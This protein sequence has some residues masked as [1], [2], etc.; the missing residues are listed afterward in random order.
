MKEIFTKFG[1]TQA[2]FTKAFW[3][4][5][6]N[7]IFAAA[8]IIAI[9]IFYKLTARIIEA[10]LRRTAMQPS[11]IRIAVHSI[12]KSTIAAVAVIIVLGLLGIDVTAALAGVGIVSI[13]IGFAAKEALANVMSGFGIFIDRLYKNG[14]WV[15]IGG[16]YGEV[17]DI[18]LR[19]TKI[20]T[21]DNLAVTIP[22]AMVTSSPITNYSEQGII[23]ITAKVSI[24]FSEST[25]AARKVLLQAAKKVEGIS[26][27]PA[28]TVV[29]EELAE[30]G[31]SLLI[32]A[33]IT[34]P[35]TEPASRFRLT[36]ACKDALDKAKIEIPFPQRSVRI[37]DSKPTTKTKKPKT[38]Q[39]KEPA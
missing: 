36:E 34:D 10:G 5:I 1:Y 3:A 9:I 37:I 31:V 11:L 29:V 27:D 4:F 25:E 20:L 26:V 8:A 14:D 39:T 35:S 7:V 12:Y 21:L 18:T 38:E 33:W 6:P 24:A 30:S 32:R 28:P 17:K 22:N 19:T 23:R 15:N 13:A 2:E 16:Q